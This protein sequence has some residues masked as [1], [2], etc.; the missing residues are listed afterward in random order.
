MKITIDIPDIESA[1]KALNNAAAVLGWAS[2][3]ASIGCKLPDRLSK[4]SELEEE[5]LKRRFL[6]V[7]SICEQVEVIEK[8]KRRDE[9]GFVGKGED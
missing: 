7:K 8:I 6:L 1:A 2:W 9:D 3:T 4:M 5:E